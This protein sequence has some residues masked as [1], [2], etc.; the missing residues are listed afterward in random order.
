MKKT[1]LGQAEWEILRYVI[2]HHPATVR[3]WPITLPRRE[4]RPAL[5]F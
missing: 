4:A 3:G 1:N 2:E 5:P